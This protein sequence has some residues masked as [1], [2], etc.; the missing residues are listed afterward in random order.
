MCATKPDFFMFIILIFQ[1]LFILFFCVSIATSMCTRSIS[2]AQRSNLELELIVS[3][4]VGAGNWTWIFYKSHK[5]SFLLSY[6][7]YQILIF[8]FFLKKIY[9]F[10]Y[11]LYVSTL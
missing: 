2:D 3:L 7:S 1:G 6:L 8:F 5:C 9:L 4:H 10:I 11:L